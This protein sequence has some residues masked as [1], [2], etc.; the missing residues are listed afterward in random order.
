M[1]L[2]FEDN[3]Q[4]KIWRP[5]K[6]QAK[7]ESMKVGLSREDAFCWLK[8]IIGINQIATRSRQI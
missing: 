8:W 7:K 5:R 1:A 6:K 2:D 4:G 3:C